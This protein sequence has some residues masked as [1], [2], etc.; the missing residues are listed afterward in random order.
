MQNPNGKKAVEVRIFGNKHQVSKM[1]LVPVENT[2]I[3]CHT[4]TMVFGI[5]KKQNS[6]VFLTS[7]LG[8]YLCKIKILGCVK[9]I[10][11][12]IMC[13]LKDTHI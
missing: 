7:L 8:F 4:C 11:N 1:S 10:V 12:A 6:V 5:E 2:S 3:G 9:N 13:P